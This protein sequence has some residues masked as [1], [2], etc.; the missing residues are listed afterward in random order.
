MDTATIC[1]FCNSKLDGED[2]GF[3]WS[4]GNPTKVSAIEVARIQDA[5]NEKKLEFQISLQNEDGYEKIPPSWGLALNLAW[6]FIWRIFAI[7][8]VFRLLLRIVALMF[9]YSR[10]PPLLELALTLIISIF[11]A[12]WAMK[13]LISRRGEHFVVVYKKVKVSD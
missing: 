7:S 4:C 6:S 9:P 3:C 5:E 2:V 8:F 1:Q 11:S 13:R 10:M 12:A